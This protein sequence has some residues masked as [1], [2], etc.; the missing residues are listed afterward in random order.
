MLQTHYCFGRFI[1]KQSTR[2]YDSWM[3][4]I[5]RQIFVVITEKI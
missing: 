4:E 1:Q 2:S 3:A 5:K